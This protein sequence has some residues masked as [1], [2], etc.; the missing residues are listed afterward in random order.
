[1]SDELKEF[2]LSQRI[3]TSRTTAFNAQGNGQVERHNGIIWQTVSLAL[4]S[5]NL[6]ITSWE[7]GARC[8]TTLHTLIALYCLQLRPS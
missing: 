5:N 6:P 1:M 8:S 4:R 3:A 7:K 2:L